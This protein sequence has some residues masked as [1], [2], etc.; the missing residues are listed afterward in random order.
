[1]KRI[2]KYAVLTLSFAAM[3]F[4]ACACGT[5]TSST[6]TEEATIEATE[7]PGALQNSKYLTVFP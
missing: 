3:A 1:M 5:S 7:V 4:A 6:T 2:T